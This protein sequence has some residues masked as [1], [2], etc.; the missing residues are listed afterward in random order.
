MQ[1]LFDEGM[2]CEFVVMLVKELYSNY[3]GG[4]AEKKKKNLTT[5]VI[6]NIC[7]GVTGVGCMG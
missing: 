4:F 1:C 2:W 5:V 3:R 6:C 7:M